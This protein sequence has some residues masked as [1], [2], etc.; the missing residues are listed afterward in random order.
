L[1]AQQSWELAVEK[2][3][4]QVGERDVDRCA[5]FDVSE[6][7]PGAIVRAELPD[8][9]VT[10]R[11]V[12]SP[13]ELPKTVTALILLPPALPTQPASPA[14][15][16]VLDVPHPMIDR[17]P[18]AERA[19]S[20]APRAAS[21]NGFE[22]GLGP[23]GRFGY[24]AAKSV[25]AGASSFAQWRF[26]GWL[27]GIAGRASHSVGRSTAVLPQWSAEQTFAAGLLLGRRFVLRSLE[28]DALL[29]LPNLAFE[30][31]T[32][33]TLSTAGGDDAD[34]ANEV[35]TTSHDQTLTYTSL[36]Y[37]VSIRASLPFSRVMRAY[38]A[39]DADRSWRRFAVSNTSADSSPTIPTW[40]AGLSLGLRW[41]VL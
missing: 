23:A 13:D 3:K 1:Q 5:A 18:S 38:V 27:V 24:D 4:R 29:E 32:F 25:A 10:E 16:A 26:Q 11:S 2:T 14:S 20:V 36:S 28:L 22:L 21:T 17:A 39:L 19:S 37:G 7:R 8:G 12:A 33:T 6:R 35:H 41:N 15:P 34:D 40:G 30:R 9:R 31:F